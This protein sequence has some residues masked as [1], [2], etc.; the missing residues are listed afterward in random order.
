VNEVAPAPLRL[1]VVV[2]TD[3][4]PFDRVISWVDGWLARQGGSVSA[5]VQHG[6][7]AAPRLAAGHA[8]LGHTDL[9]AFIRTAE[10]IVTHGGPAT[11]TEVRRRGLR[12]IVVPRDPALGEHVDGHQ[13][14]FARRMGAAGLVQLCEDRESLEL[15]L[16]AV[17]A[18]PALVQLAAGPQAHAGD[19]AVAAT[20][21]RIGR[22]VDDLASAGPRPPLTS[23]RRRPLR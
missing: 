6:S 4:H 23:L 7:S 2:G 3:H 17:R 20:V 15:A 10:V 18:D 16:D 8:M 14:R 9:Q 21:A 1:L 13:Q 22:I 5:V 11:I 19:P 12:P